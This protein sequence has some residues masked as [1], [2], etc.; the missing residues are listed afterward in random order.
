[1]L[2]INRE[3]LYFL[4]CEKLLEI[5]PEATHLFEEPGTLD[6]AAS[7]AARWLSSHLH[8]RVLEPTV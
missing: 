2:T 5:V 7:S 4:G 8:T 6:R 3:T 1:M